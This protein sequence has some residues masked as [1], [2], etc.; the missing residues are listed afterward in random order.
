M[1]LILTPDLSVYPLPPH[2]THDLTPVRSS[3]DVN[4]V[5]EQ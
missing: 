5:M 3:P 2:T 1:I 4:N